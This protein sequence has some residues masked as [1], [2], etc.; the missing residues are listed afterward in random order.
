MA[1]RA[2]SGDDQPAP[3]H[4]KLDKRN[5]QTA[6]S[7]REDVN[8]WHIL[9]RFLTT[10]M[11]YPEMDDALLSY[12]G[13]QYSPDD[14]KDARVALFSG[15]SDDCVALSNLRI[16]M[17][18]N[19]SQSLSDTASMAKDSPIA[20]S[21]SRKEVR[22]AKDSR[23]PRNFRRFIDDEAGESEDEEDEEGEE[24]EGDVGDGPSVRSHNITSVPG[25]L[26][27]LKLAVAIDSI[28]DKYDQAPQSSSERCL[29]YRAAWSPG[30][31][32]SR[33]YLLIVHRTATRYIAEHLRAKKFPVT[34]S[35]WLPGQLYVVSDSPKT[36]AASLPPSHS[37]SMKEYL[38]ISQEECEMVECSN[39]QLPNPLWVRIKHGKY[40]GDIGYIF[41]PDQSDLFVTVLIPP[42]EFPY[43]MPQGSVALLDQ[44][45]LPKDN[46]VSDILL[47]GDV[48]GC[49]YK[50][51]RYYRGLLLKNCL[52]YS[53]ELVASPHV[54]DIR[55]HV[56]SRWDKDFVKNTIAA[57]SMQFL[58][59]GDAVRVTKGEVHSEIGTVVST[60]HMSGTV[61]LEYRAHI[62]GG[63]AV[64]VVAGLYSGLEGHIIQAN[65]GD[66]FDV[67]QDVSQEVVQVS[68]YYLDHRPPNYTYQSWLST[69]QH[70][71]H[72]FDESIQV[73][74]YIE[75][76]FGEHTGK[77]GVVVW[78]PAGDTQLWFRYANIGTKDNTE[79]SPRP[80]IF[81]VPATLVR[82]TGLS[83]TLKY[84]K[85]K[86]FDVKPGD[87]MRV[88]RGPEYQVKGVVQSVDFPK[89][90]LTLLSE[91]DRSLVDVPIDF[92]MKLRNAP[93][94]SFKDVIGQEVFVIGG[95]RK[96]YR[97][98]LYS[99]G[100]ESCTV[101]VHGQARTECKR[102]DVATRYGMRLDGVM[103]EA[104]D[105]MSFCD[106]RKR[107]YLKSP[108]RRFTTPPP[109]PV[110]SEL[111]SSINP[112]PSLSLSIWTNWSASLTDINAAHD[113]SS[114]ATSSSDPWTFNAQDMQDNIS[115][116]VEQV[117]D[118][119]PLP[120]LMSK[121]F[122]SL[123]LTYHAVFR[124]SPSFMGGRLHKPAPEDSVAVF[125]TSNNVGAAVQQYHIPAKYLSPAPP[126]KKNQWCLILDG[127][128]HGQILTI[129]KCNV[130]QNTAEF[131]IE[132]DTGITLHFDQI[133]LV[134][135]AQ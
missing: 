80:P 121:E 67:C 49:L 116:M 123:L 34:V 97:A 96:G 26:A 45:R 69:Q 78:F 107:S 15:D 85:E 57:F 65:N 127:K 113:P 122:S 117:K 120:W 66:I 17:A 111:P 75:A 133:C 84:T 82:R 52:R 74:D 94:D 92:V 106:M 42:R 58:C 20:T 41:N 124:V 25:P 37:L 43:D 5:C 9:E 48:V 63:S 125:C 35:A 126:R 93:L 70:F 89:A 109:D 102:H 98:T 30:T 100:S 72:C 104:S 95:G 108:P 79:Y 38:H 99:I 88:T 2:A 24:G 83:Q 10:E 59:K 115:S 60:H 46:T 64:R 33:M 81:Q 12:L 3:K 51:Q 23:T 13:D 129:S 62:L 73:G 53:I 6:P 131:V 31:I 11:T 56:Q 22:R 91:S 16:L 114:I 54:D 76:L 110:P 68:K 8:A 55:L 77:C 14:W 103:L 132:G 61:C 87:V 7:P 130:K 112:D 21:A 50:G 36:I 44:S 19:L 4:A 28:F 47:D 1:K 128:S 39:I 118:N 134:K 86:G 119:G 32:E 135:Q 71:E 40:K 29:P 27:K 105:L 101:A 18:A 90:R